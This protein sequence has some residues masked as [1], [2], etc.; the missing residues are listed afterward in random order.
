MRYLL[1][2]L[3]S[4]RSI[5]V[6]PVADILPI[7]TPSKA[8]LSSISEADLCRI[9]HKLSIRRHIGVNVRWSGFH[10]TTKSGPNGP[11]LLRSTS[12]FGL[13]INTFGPELKT[14]GGELFTKTCDFLQGKLISSDDIILGK[15]AYF[16]DKEG[17]TR[18]VAMCDYWTQTVL[19][20][21]HEKLMFL[22]RGFP[23]DCTFDHNRAIPYLLNLSGPYHSLDLS[24]ATDRM[25][26]WLQITIM[27][28]IFGSNKSSAWGR[29]L[30]GRDYTLRDVSSGRS[31]EIKNLRYAVGQ[32]MGA[33]SS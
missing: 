30:V 11:A 8:S 4:L 1:T 22:L 13:A 26:F 7:I 19:K 9:M 10:F 3:S 16:S 28:F 17:K 14:L 33:Y 15:L 5:M 29:L 31:G 23:T 12:E 20:P 32:P 6:P 27:N 18:L 21:Y 25:P 2:L 24:N